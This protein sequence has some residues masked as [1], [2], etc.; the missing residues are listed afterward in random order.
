MRRLTPT[1]A[2]TV[3]PADSVANLAQALAED[4]GMVMKAVLI[5]D[6]IDEEGERNLNFVVTDKT[7]TWDLQG[8]LT[9][10]LDV[11]GNKYRKRS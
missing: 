8:M 3:T 11:T 5:Y 9:G 6:M 10:I 1:I 7:A 4:G 2:A